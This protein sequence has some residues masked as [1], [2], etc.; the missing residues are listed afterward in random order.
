[1]VSTPTVVAGSIPEFSTCLFHVVPRVPGGAADEKTGPVVPYRRIR[2][3]LANCVHLLG[4]K[5][6]Y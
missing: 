5:C 2:P 1:M 3:V 6:N 4:S